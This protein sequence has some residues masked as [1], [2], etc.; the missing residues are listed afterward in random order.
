[1]FAD[2]DLLLLGREQL[3]ICDNDQVQEVIG[4]ARP[5]VVINTAAFVR[6]DDADGEI[7]Q[8][9][10]VNAGGSRAGGAGVCGQP[11]QRW[12]RS[13]RTTC[14]VGSSSGSR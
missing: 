7:A 12:S 1:M 14:T 4:V 2:H 6:V 5:D 9:F 3:D 8:S 11:A 13:A 10:A